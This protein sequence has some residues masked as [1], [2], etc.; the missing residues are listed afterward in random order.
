MKKA[1]RKEM[2]QERRSLSDELWREKSHEILSRIMASDLLKGADTIM[3]FMDFRKEVMTRPI[4]EWL[5]TQNKKV[6]IPRVKEN[7]PILELC[8]IESFDDM[9]L[10]PLGIWEPKSD[11]KALACPDEVDFV[12]MPGVAFTKDGGRLGYGGGY[13]DQLIPLMNRAVP[14]VA[15]AFDL[16]LVDNLPLEDHDIRIDKIITESALIQ[17]R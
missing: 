12:F 11:H 15:L 16:Q 9:E 6:I 1:L 4:I 13:Y 8:V 17:C 3:I 5:W 2:I 7:D 10:S 14:L